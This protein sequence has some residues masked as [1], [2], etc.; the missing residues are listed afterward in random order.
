MYRVEQATL[1]R[2]HMARV[3]NATLAAM[4]RVGLHDKGTT[5]AAATAFVIVRR[6]AAN[7]AASQQECLYAVGE[8]LLTRELGQRNYDVCQSFSQRSR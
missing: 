1:R 2:D 5:G 6:G 3:A 4:Y 7:A 8:V